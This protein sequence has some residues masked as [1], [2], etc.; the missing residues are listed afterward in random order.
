[1]CGIV[2]HGQAAGADS[3][4]GP[5][6]LQFS[7]RLGVSAHWAIG[8]NSGVLMIPKKNVPGNTASGKSTLKNWL[9]D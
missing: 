3:C 6:L 4:T 9:A 5:V 8:I 1:M 7:Y 2:L